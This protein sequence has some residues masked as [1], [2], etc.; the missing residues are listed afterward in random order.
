MQPG[1]T[2]EQANAKLAILRRSLDKEMAK[3]KKDWTFRVEPYAQMLVGDNL[4]QSI[5]VGF[6]AV[7][8][9][10]LIA[11]ANVAD[12]LLAQ[13]AARQK[14][15][16]LRAALGASRGRL[17][18]QLLTESWVLCLLGGVAGVALAYAALK[19]RRA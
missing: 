14:E 13:G 19:P 7:L 8:M 10:L 9:V 12:L 17:V 1:V 15:M 4:R 16:A 11:C 2:I 6:G 18:L 5:Y 3:F